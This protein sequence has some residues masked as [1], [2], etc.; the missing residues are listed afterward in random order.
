LRS[1]NYLIVKIGLDWIRSK[2]IAPIL[3]YRTAR[4]FARRLTKSIALN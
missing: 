4:V 3:P 1:G 2:S